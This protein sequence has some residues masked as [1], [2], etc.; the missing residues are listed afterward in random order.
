MKTRKTGTSSG[1]SVINGGTLVIP[2][3]AVIWAAV[4]VIGILLGGYVVLFGWLAGEVVS[5]GKE[6]AALAEAVERIDADL[7]ELKEGQERLRDDME[8]GFDRI[9]DRFEGIEDRFEGFEDRF[10]RFEDILRGRDTPE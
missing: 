7:I 6:Q 1:A 9:E 8:R 2:V 4:V 5:L 3:K 10:D